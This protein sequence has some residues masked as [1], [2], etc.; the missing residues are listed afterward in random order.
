MSNPVSKPI[1]YKRARFSTY[2]P[3]GRLYSPTHFWAERVEEGVWRVGFTKFATRMLGEIVECVFEV[4]PDEEVTVGQV[5]GSVEAFKAITDLY[6]VVE[7]T[8]IRGNPTINEDS[9][10]ISSFPY[11][12]GWLYQV[13][14]EPDERFTDVHQYV[15]LLN[16]TIDRMQEKEIENGE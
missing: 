4:Q 13:R 14:G 16:Q 12:R 8:F 6:C 5:I 1:H 11:D 3:Q 9:S 7:G 15:E 10:I 2:L